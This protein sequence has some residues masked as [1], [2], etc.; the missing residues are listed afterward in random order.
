MFLCFFDLN[1]FYNKRNKQERTTNNHDDPY[2]EDHFIICLIKFFHGVIAFIVLQFDHKQLINKREQ[3]EKEVN[4]SIV[5]EVTFA[6]IE[7]YFD[8]AL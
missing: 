1:E 2:L 7:V 6:R 8:N 3:K 5:S 4:N